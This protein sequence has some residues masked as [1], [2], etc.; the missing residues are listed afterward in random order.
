[1]AGNEGKVKKSKIIHTIIGIC[2]MIFFQFLPVNL[3]S[4]T[5]VG[6]QILG[7]FLGTLY[8]WTT[9]DILWSSLLCLGAIGISAY[10]TMDTMLE[11]MLGNSTLM[12]MLFIMILSGA[13]VKFKLTDYIARFFLTRK[14]TKD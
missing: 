11:S 3:P 2:I 7:I 14:I 8:L 9:V 13:L 6:M 4:V 10:T 1:M 12:L 5:D